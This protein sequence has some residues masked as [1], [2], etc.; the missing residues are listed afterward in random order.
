MGDPR[1]GRK[2]YNSPGHPY[3]K[4]RIENELVI[5]GKYGLRNKKELWK[6]RTKLANYRSQARS[7]L[8]VDLEIRADREKLLIDKLNRLGIIT[9]DT[10]IDDILSLEVETILKRRLQTQVL[11]RGLAGT[12]YQARQLITH[13]HIMVNGRIMTSPSYIVPIEL[14]NEIAYASTSPFGDEAH[15]MNASLSRESTILEIPEKKILRRR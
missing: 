13:R 4:A 3:Q 6:A 10:E 11:E 2:K 8:G 1:K 5:I 15:S 14:E 12:I 7:L 9:V